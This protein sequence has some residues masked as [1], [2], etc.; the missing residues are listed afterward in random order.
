MREEFDSKCVLVSREKKLCKKRNRLFL[1]ISQTKRF[2]H[3]S[4]SRKKSKMNYFSHNILFQIPEI[5]FNVRVFSNLWLVNVFVSLTSQTKPMYFLEKKVILWPKSMKKLGI[6]EADKNIFF[7]IE[8]LQ[9][10][11]YSRFFG[12]WTFW[13]QFINTW[14]GNFEKISHPFQLK[15]L[16]RPINHSSLLLWQAN[17]K[18]ST[19]S[20]FFTFFEKDF[21]PIKLRFKHFPSNQRL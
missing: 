7:P 21:R 11:L 15:I 12:V 4:F 1:I 13:P 19:Q 18:S 17:M 10:S 6:L 5:F 3:D 20:N 14:A 2:K 9:I 16:S 8:P